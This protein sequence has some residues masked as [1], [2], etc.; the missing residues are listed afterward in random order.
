MGCMPPAA[1]PAVRAARRKSRALTGPTGSS[2]SSYCTFSQKYTEGSSWKAT[3]VE[4]LVWL[5]SSNELESLEDYMELLAVPYPFGCQTYSNGLFRKQ[6]ADGI[7]G[8]SLHETSLVTAFYNDGLISANAFSLCVT[9]KGGVLSLGGS[10][11]PNHYHGAP[12]KTTPIVDRH[13]ERGYYSVSVVR[14][15]VGGI[16]I[17][18]STTKPGLLERVN[19]GKGCILDSGTTDSYFPAGLAKA[20]RK[21]AAEHAQRNG[22]SNNASDNVFSERLRRKHYTL[23]EFESLLPEITIVFANNVELVIP[24]KHYMESVPLDDSGNIVAWRGSLELTNRLYFEEA[25]GSVLGANAMFGYDIFFDGG[26]EH[27]A[28]RVGIAPADCHTAAKQI[29]TG[30]GSASIG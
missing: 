22:N 1:P 20:F 8:L 19:S 11:D 12:M 16:T 18:D 14:L 15:L 2:E 4:D 17:A 26:D 10:L 3:E 6:Y 7:L 23:Q 28:A 9:P 25:D 21:A 29:H 30:V 5:G 13:R 24:P 27:D